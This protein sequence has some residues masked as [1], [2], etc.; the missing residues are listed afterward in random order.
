M[1]IFTTA[2]KVIYIDLKYTIMVGSAIKKVEINEKRYLK[3][4]EVVKFLEFRSYSVN[5]GNK[6]VHRHQDHLG[7]FH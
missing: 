3:P 7:N 2:T 6:I 5:L 4:G 1:N